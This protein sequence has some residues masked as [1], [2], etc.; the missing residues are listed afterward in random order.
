[1]TPE[2]RKALQEQFQKFD[3]AGQIRVLEAL[4]LLEKY[5]LIEP[6]SR[7]YEPLLPAHY[8]AIEIEVSL[9][10]SLRVHALGVMLP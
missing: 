9:A 3:L 4:R 5:R 2:K 6:A 8:R 10:D 7:Y 1:M